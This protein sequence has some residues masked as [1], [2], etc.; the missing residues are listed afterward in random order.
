MDI[1]D[2]NISESSKKELYSFSKNNFNVFI[3][4]GMMIFGIVIC[5]SVIVYSH[6]ESWKYLLMIDTEDTFM[7][8]F[9][10]VS[11]VY[12]GN[13]YKYLVNYPAFPFLIF[14][15]V[16]RIIPSSIDLS[17]GFAIRNFSGGM[18]ICFTFFAAQLFIMAKLFLMKFNN[19]QYKNVLTV[20]LLL[21][22]PIIF[23]IERGN[24]ILL[25]FLFSLI[26]VLNY[27]STNKINQIIANVCLAMAAAIKIYPAILFFLYLKNKDYKN[28]V[29]G[30]ILSFLFFIIPFFFFGGIDSII[31]MV[32]SL[33]R[34][35]TEGQQIG[36]GSSFSLLTICNIFCKL[37]DINFPYFYIS[38]FSAFIVSLLFNFCISK[39]KIDSVLLLALSIIIIPSISYTYSLIFLILPLIFI[40]K[41]KTNYWYYVIFITLILIPYCFSGIDIA[42][43]G[44]NVRYPLT[45]GNII[46]LLS[47]VVLYLTITL[48]NLHLIIYKKGKSFD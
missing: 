4:A 20:L 39:S 41:S 13:P 21:S 1:K 11:R 15:I 22:G 3:F 37:F 16:F 5:L 24:I 33:L 10:S 34:T 40:L 9:H 43:V 30:G 29:F 45:Y 25:A 47:L 38:I 28:F 27:D 19:V 14:K 7:D 23:T 2:S 31:S 46:Q 32:N 44:N 8:F 35:T 26:F 6:G 12:G 17:D 36:Y 18:I 42:G 48:K